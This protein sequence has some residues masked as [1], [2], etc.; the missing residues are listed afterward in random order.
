MSVAQ[1]S[2]VEESVKDEVQCELWTGESGAVVCAELSKSTE[3]M[4]SD[5]LTD[6]RSSGLS[7]TDKHSMRSCLSSPLDLD[8]DCPSQLRKQKVVAHVFEHLSVGGRHR[9][10]S[11]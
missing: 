4:W 1:Q 7:S 10:G 8:I 3:H 2:L 6:W 9:E 5:T 11:R